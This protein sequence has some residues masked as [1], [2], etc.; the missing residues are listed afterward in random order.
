MFRLYL[1][2]VERLDA[3]VARRIATKALGPEWAERE[4][5]RRA[6]ERAGVNVTRHQT[7]PS[8]P[9]PRETP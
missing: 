8:A 4:K 3:W 7:H 5:L 2:L 1:L 9:P 6:M